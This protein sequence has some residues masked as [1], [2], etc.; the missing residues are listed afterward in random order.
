M[1]LL[2]HGLKIKRYTQVYQCPNDNV[3]AEESIFVKQNRRTFV[4][5]LGFMLIA[6]LAGK[7]IGKISTKKNTKN[8]I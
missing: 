1:E 5:I 2:G 8:L 6:V 7:R 4:K 3:R